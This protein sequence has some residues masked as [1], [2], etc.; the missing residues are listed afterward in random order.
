MPR[1]TKR[2]FTLHTLN[3]VLIALSETMTDISLIMTAL[4]SQLTTSSV[5]IG[6]LA[7]MRDT[8]WFLPQLFISNLVERAPRKIVFYQVVTFFRVGGWMAL[9]ACLFLIE[10]RTTLLLAFFICTAVIALAGGMGGIS[11]LTVTAK[12]I[13]SGQRGLL[14]GLREFIGGGLSIFIG[15]LSAF[16]LAGQ[17]GGQ[18]FWFPRNFGLLF[19]ISTVFFTA[20]CIAFGLLAEPPDA[21]PAHKTSLTQQLSR[22]AH[23]LKTDVL[24]RRF[25][26]TRIALLF[27]RTGVPFITVFAKRSMGVSDA[28][29][30]TLVSVTLGSALFAGLFWGR[31]NDR[32]GSHAVLIASCLLG[33]AQCV[34]GL[35]LLPTHSAAL[36]VGALVLGGVSS[37]G[38]NVAMIPLLF[39]V[40]P[41]EERPLYIGLGNTLL[42]VVMLLTSLVGLIVDYLGFA[43]CFVFCALCFLLAL[44]RVLKLQQKTG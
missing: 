40:V 42:G 10:D 2:N 4:V 25:I 19:A 38:F 1:A 36:L 11:Y 43:A 6:L 31:L 28:F 30:G 15:G 35:L 29:I 8:G 13:P 26:F 3:G 21:V 44:E 23:A 22:A 32:R 14:F 18:T 16:I 33:V 7:P 37:A 27:A 5:L 24:F 9:V 20:G 12:V 34:L 39:E 41:A 17:V